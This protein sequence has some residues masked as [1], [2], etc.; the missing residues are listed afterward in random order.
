MRLKK[1]SCRCYRARCAQLST[2]TSKETFVSP[3]A[4]WVQAPSRAESSAAVIA[5]AV[6]ESGPGDATNTA[7][8]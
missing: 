3:N 1:T 2:G 7:S 5:F 4:A 6:A 8:R